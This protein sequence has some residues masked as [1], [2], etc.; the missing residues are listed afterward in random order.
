MANQHILFHLEEKKGCGVERVGL[1][2]G[3]GRSCRVGDNHDQNTMYENYFIKKLKEKIY[4]HGRRNEEEE[5]EEEEG[6]EEKEE[7][8]EEEAH[9]ITSSRLSLLNK[10]LKK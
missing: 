9:R 1:W 7:E 10:L 8:G 5:E 2:E 6:E 3:S 4:K